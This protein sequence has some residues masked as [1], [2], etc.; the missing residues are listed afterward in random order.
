MDLGGGDRATGNAV[1]ALKSIA[2][3]LQTIFLQ[4]VEMGLPRPSHCRPID[5]LPTHL[6]NHDL[7]GRY[8]RPKQFVEGF[9]RDADD[10]FKTFPRYAPRPGNSQR[11]CR[12]V[13][14]F[15]DAM[16]EP[17][18]EGCFPHEDMY[19]FRKRLCDRRRG[20][21]GCPGWFAFCARKNDARSAIEC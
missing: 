11:Q 9:G 4:G 18:M 2:D 21:P 16:F 8:E 12:C 14:D 3:S 13:G 15:L 6:H 1:V 17:F 10:L 5:H 19:A 7:A 20:L